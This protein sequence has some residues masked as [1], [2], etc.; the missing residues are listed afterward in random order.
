MK[1][2]RPQSPVPDVL[3]RSSPPLRL[4][5]VLLAGGVVF[6][7]ALAGCSKA[8]ASGNP[9]GSASA[10]QVRGAKTYSAKGVIKSFG[11]DRKSVNIA[12]EEIPGYMAAMTMSFEAGS[13]GQLDGVAVGDKITFSFR[14]EEDGRQVL[15]EIKKEP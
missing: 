9:T 5:A 1:G 10:S 6:A 12:H 3:D 4:F 8:T 11:P 7:G 14:S 2:M 13:P 15:T